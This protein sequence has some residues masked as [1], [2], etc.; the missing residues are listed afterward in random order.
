MAEPGGREALLVRRDGLGN[1]DVL[2]RRAL[3]QQVVV[4][5]H[6]A[7]AGGPHGG[8]A[9][10]GAAPRIPEVVAVATIATPSEPVRNITA[11][12]RRGYNR[13]P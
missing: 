1:E 9:V 11:R 6:E 3:R 7:H 13:A 4:L 5:E 2:E 12:A 10:L 8:A